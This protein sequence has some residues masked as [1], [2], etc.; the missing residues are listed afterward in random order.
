M[1]VMGLILAYLALTENPLQHR[2]HTVC[3]IF[4]VK[5]LRLRKQA[6]CDLE[7]SHAPSVR[8]PHSMAFQLST[9]HRKIGSLF[10][11]PRLWAS[12]KQEQIG[13]VRE[14]LQEQIGA[15]REC[16]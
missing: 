15:V 9:A 6:W 2:F 1:W 5:P 12:N 11:L 14:C 3:K 10:C 16:L 4:E 8:V 7:P 13:A